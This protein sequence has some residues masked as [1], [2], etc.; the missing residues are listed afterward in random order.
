[1]KKILYLLSFILFVSLISNSCKDTID[2]CEGVECNNGDCLLGNCQCDYGWSGSDCSVKKSSFFYADWVG[3]LKCLTNTDTVTM[4]IEEIGSS[5]DV[6]KMHTV[7][8]VF[9]LGTIPVSFDNYT[10]NG[11]LDS[12]FEAFVIDTLNIKQIIPFNG[13]NIEV[14]IGVSGTGKKIEEDKLDIKLDFL[15]K[16]FNQSISCTGVFAKP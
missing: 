13:N 8:L 3:E 4:R 16:Q 9:N 14:E 12:T 10:L 1:M 2:E 7:G 6:L 15:I 5:V 11:V